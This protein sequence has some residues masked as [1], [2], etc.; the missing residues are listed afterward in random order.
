MKGQPRKRGVE[1]EKE[2]MGHRGEAERAAQEGGRG[3]GSQNERFIP[4]VRGVQPGQGGVGEIEQQE[5]QQRIRAQRDLPPRPVAVFPFLPGSL[6]RLPLQLSKE[7]SKD[8]GQSPS[9]RERFYAARK[10]SLGDPGGTTPASR[11]IR[12]PARLP[13]SIRSQ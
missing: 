4:G 2:E 3:Q 9:Q 13:G 10:T 5:G 1:R 12:Q 6:K 7:V 8:A 11:G